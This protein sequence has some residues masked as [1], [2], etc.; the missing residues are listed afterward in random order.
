MRKHIITTLILPLFFGCQSKPL[1]KEGNNSTGHENRTIHDKELSE[2]KS[3]P[4]EPKKLI[5]NT[6]EDYAQLTSK[7]ELIN[8]FGKENVKHGVSLYAEGSV[9]LKH[10]IVTNPKNKHV[11][12]YLWNEENPKKLSFLEV[13]Y[14]DYNEEYEVQGNQ[15]VLSNCGFYTGMPINDLRKWNGADFEFSG[16]GWDYEGGVSVQPKSRLNSC[17]V[18][19]KL[20]LKLTESMNGLDELYGDVELNTSNQ[21]VKKAPIIIDRLYYN[22]GN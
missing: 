19:I 7:E 16:F 22:M 5:F 17:H 6:I 18:G 13:D 1:E 15:K 8:T 10:S 4:E 3:T 14:Y 11:I 20:G 12:K 9:E 2:A 21:L